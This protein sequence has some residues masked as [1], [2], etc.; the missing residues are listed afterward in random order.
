MFSSLFVLSGF[1]C[2]HYTMHRVKMTECEGEPKWG[3]EEE[4]W[5]VQNGPDQS[6]MIASGEIVRVVGGQID[7][8]VVGTGGGGCVSR[9][10]RRL[11]I[12]R[13]LREPGSS[14]RAGRLFIHIPK[15]DSVGGSSAFDEPLCAP[16]QLSCAS[17]CV[18]RSARSLKWWLTNVGF[19]LA[20]TER[21]AWLTGKQIMLRCY[22][23]IL[24]L[25]NVT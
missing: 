22:V 19:S 6:R 16:A 3:G 2:R 13:H 15:P 17:V 12:S 7:G 8:W 18:C 1:L 4:A 25:V 10:G 11:I 24:L 20:N 14:L 23:F 9:I 5:E 21:A